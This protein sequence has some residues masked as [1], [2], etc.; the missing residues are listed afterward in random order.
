M[1]RAMLL[2]C[3]LSQVFAERLGIETTAEP[4]IN[5]KKR[6]QEASA[7]LR[8]PSCS[9]NVGLYNDLIHPVDLRI[10]K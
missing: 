1:Q 3:I 2:V 5:A 6:T 4:T 9:G 10:W 8:I 7:E